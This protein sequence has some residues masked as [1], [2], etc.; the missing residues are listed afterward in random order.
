MDRDN[1]MTAILQHLGGAVFLLGLSL[2]IKEEEHLQRFLWVALI[3]AALMSVI[4]V[5]QQFEVFS[6]FVPES[7]GTMATGFYGH[8]NVLATYLLLHF[9]LTIYFY[10]SSQTI[11]KKIITG[12]IFILIV[13]A[14]I[15]TRSRGGQVVLAVQLLCMLIY[16]VQKKD[17]SK[18]R[19]FF[20]GLGL[21]TA[22]YFGLIYLIKLSAVEQHFDTPPSIANVFTGE[23]NA[24]GGL[25]NR[26]VFWKTGWGIFKDYWLTGTGPWT[27][28]LLFP[29]Y[30]GKET[31]GL[32]EGFAYVV[33]P[34]HSHNIFC[35]N[36]Y[37][38]RGNRV[39]TFYGFS[40]RVLFSG[41]LPF[42]KCSSRDQKFCF[43]PHPVSPPD[44]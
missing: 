7:T 15:F 32:V 44:L 20:I 35:S 28:E 23:L 14:L 36:S 24:W 33:N 13:L 19:D 30:L 29:V 40:D 8:R 26:L 21:I 12:I 39:R 10:F 9:P 6:S 16:L 43:L 37:G 22:L 11:N 42:T 25:A 18:V 27:F 1:S 4:A 38:H 34:P 17:H 31:S 2:N 3:C 41:N 5:V